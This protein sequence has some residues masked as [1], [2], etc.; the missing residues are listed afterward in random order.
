MLEAKFTD[1][2]DYMYQQN[3]QKI[4]KINGGYDLG[5]MRV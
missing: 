5:K 2:R 3:K 4:F 1:K